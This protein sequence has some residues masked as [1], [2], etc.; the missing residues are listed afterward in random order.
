MLK[1][2]MT[3]STERASTFLRQ[4]CPQLAR[5]AMA[6]MLTRTGQDIKEAEK[7]EIAAVFDRPIPFTRNSVYLR[8]AN[9]RNLEAIVWLKDSNDVSA[10]QYLATQI[11]GGSGRP[12]KRFEKALQAA[13]N[14]PR[15]WYALP[16]KGMKLDAHG[17]MPPA[18]IVQILSATKSFSEQ[19][20]T[21]NR[22]AQSRARRGAKLR[23][24]FVSGPVNAARAPNGGR[25][26]FG[27]WERVGRGPSKKIVCLLMFV[28]RVKY[29]ALFDF[30]GVADRTAKRVMDSHWS[31]AFVEAFE[32][33]ERSARAVA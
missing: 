9:Q 10:R 33:F 14:M 18:L 29:R 11:N 12:L 16:G 24:I 1:L 5:Y 20:Y 26:P 31:R 13:G 23:D 28:P 2:G 3:A 25:L 4:R 30:F 17:N 7:Q 19:G 21:A 8:P 27:I 6:I 32:G 22:T 15:G